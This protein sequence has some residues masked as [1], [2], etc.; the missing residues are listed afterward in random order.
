MLRTKNEE[1][2][3]RDKEREKCKDRR[4][5]WW[6]GEK[7]ELKKYKTKSIFAPICVH[8]YLSTYY[9]NVL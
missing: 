4:W 8:M 2:K 5:N 6:K 9:V 1:L 3:E 7:K